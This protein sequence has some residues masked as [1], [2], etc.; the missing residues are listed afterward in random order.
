MNPEPA[1]DPVV[2]DGRVREVV[3][4]EAAIARL[5]ARQI[6][7][8]A[9]LDA[10]P[11][12]VIDEG[13][14]RRWVNEELAGL[15]RVSPGSAQWRLDQA[16]RF[17]RL[18][19]LMRQFSAGTIT[20]RYLNVTGEATRL[21]D[22]QLTADVDEAVVEHAVGKTPE[23]FT[24]SLRAVVL[25][26]ASAGQAERHQRA[27]KD[28]RVGVAHGEYG[29]SEL[30]GYLPTED[31]VT[32]DTVLNAMAD[33]KHPGDGRT[34]EQRRADAL[35]QLALDKLNG[36]NADLPMQQGRRPTIQVT[37]AL[38]T[39]LGID[40]QP[41]ELDDHGPIPAELA[42]KLAADPT[43]TWRRLIT[44]N[45]SRLVHYDQAKYKPPQDLIDHVIAR[46][47]RC[48][49][50]GCPRKARRC[51]LD[52]VTPHSRGGPTSRHNLQALCSRHHQLK[53][54]TGWRVSGDA[55]GTLTWTDPKGRTYQTQPAQHPTDRT[56][57]PS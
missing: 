31:A 34:R 4:L 42:R 7:V 21:L 28:R 47:V 32:L 38:S 15:L 53:H 14:D 54:K 22:D 9:E 48:R 40:D 49:F 11:P 45:R 37:V 50:P 29:M 17:M 6:R 3:R 27:R 13:L 18:P 52:H 33:V 2:H 10:E 39:L 23:A 41:G 46:D 8:L 30:F 20:L 19:R 36:T 16:R 5:Q 1:V 12:V 43:G 25:T 35:T 57:P 44:D 24:K 51:Q 55:E 56:I 26:L